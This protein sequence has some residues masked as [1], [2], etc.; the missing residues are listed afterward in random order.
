MTMLFETPR[1]EASSRAG[2]GAAA[3]WRE[4]FDSAL[5][6]TRLA[7]D[8]RSFDNA[9]EAAYANRI[10]AAKDATGQTFE[11]PMLT[12][13][14]HEDIPLG[15]EPGSS[16]Q[17]DPLAAGRFDDWI[18][19][20]AK[21]Y[22]EKASQFSG[23][24]IVEDAG[25]LA[26]SAQTREQDVFARANGVGEYSAYLAANA[27]YAATDLLNYVLAPVTG[28]AG[29]GTR[30]LL[31]AAI[32]NG[33]ANAATEAVLQPMVQ[34]W[35]RQAGLDYGVSQGAL[36]VAAAGA[37]GFGLDAGV[38]GV[39]RGVQSAAGRVPVVTDGVVTGYRPKD[40]PVDA[41]EDAARAA[42]PDSPVA[43]A[44]AG[45]DDALRTMATETGLAG[46]P[47][48]RGALNEIERAKIF[49]A[50]PEIDDGQHMMNLADAIRASMDGEAVPPMA[51]DVL[52]NPTRDWPKLDVDEATAQD[53]PSIL[54]F[55]GRKPTGERYIPGSQANAP[56]RPLLRTGTERQVS[57]KTKTGEVVRLDYSK[58]RT[59]DGSDGK[60]N[61]SVRTIYVT[62]DEAFVLRRNLSQGEGASR[63]DKLGTDKLNDGEIYIRTKKVHPEYGTFQ[64]YEPKPLSRIQFKSE[65][66]VGL[67]PLTLRGNDLSD[68]KLLGT[69]TDIGTAAEMSG[70]KAIHFE[71]VSASAVV[72]QDVIKS[73]SANGA[74]IAW[75]P[76]EG[77]A[78]LLRQ[79]GRQA[80]DG[81]EAQAFVFRETDGWSLDDV[82]VIAARKSLEEMSGSAIDMATLL[83]RRPDLADRTL[84]FTH[85]KFQQ[86]LGLTR[87]SD[88]A[89]DMIL[90]GKL[91]PQYAALIGRHVPDLSL[92]AGLVEQMAAAGVKSTGQAKAWIGQATVAPTPAQTHAVRFGQEAATSDMIVE[93]ASVLD[94]A[95]KLLV[96]NRRVFAVLEKEA[97]MI[98][99]AGN[100]LS[101]AANAQQRFMLGK[102]RDIVQKM[103]GQPGRISDL[104]QEAAVEMAAGV[105][106][107]D[108]AQTF[109]GKVASILE[110]EGISGLASSGPA[111][112][113]ETEL[114]PVKMSDPFGPE[115]KAQ[116][117]AMAREAETRLAE[118]EAFDAKVQSVW[119]NVEY[120]KSYEGFPRPQRLIDWLINNGG[121]WD[122]TGD[123][124]GIIGGVK[125]RPGL[126]RGAKGD[127]PGGG[128]GGLPGV[129]GGSRKPRGAM[130]LDDAALKAWEDGFIVSETRPTT[131][132]LLD[133]IAED[134]SGTPRVRQQDVE[135]LDEMN[136]IKDMENELDRLGV[137]KAGSEDEVRALLAAREGDIRGTLEGRQA[138]EGSAAEGAADGKLR[139]PDEQAK[140][141][142]DRAKELG[143]TVDLCKPRKT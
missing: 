134:A 75:Q 25:L 50:P 24:S 83:R 114:M 108:A 121:I 71:K 30:Q 36:N 55:I 139:A 45:D 122:Y 93:R 123:V 44:A 22:P 113:A 13:L 136:A 40:S 125:G 27:A 15:V 63:G 9:M 17:R 86:A 58:L 7:N 120:L 102:I 87:L 59:L 140:L 57:F 138:A 135:I 38:R 12:Y 76:K 89:F 60:P 91:A 54:D 97:P 53:T 107:K 106:A 68:W 77:E 132:D 90:N 84:P 80:E 133:A 117:E 41:L 100:V 19:S 66:A 105:K 143:E 119:Q 74:P 110:E 142:A 118:I 81:G 4:V 109:V 64:G 124:R 35:R 96:K 51:A 32:K 79:A 130:T 137:L 16:L 3:T 28:P 127:K 104:L 101:D 34:D 116:A 98:R 92:H 61:R 65:P 21:Q 141:D 20:L 88:E 129:G 94:Q 26:R 11:N 95:L 5:E 131:N 111:R 1:I 99:S 85:F 23:R 69:I 128:Q 47:T 37:L 6:S 10:K 18:A 48:V 52:P 112:R 78:I 29:A 43:R 72:D 46:D 31:W 67:V 70:G 8:R 56:P 33:V 14:Q 82:R 115:A 73:V 103:A 39:Y 49:G 2:P 42:P 126:V 62:E